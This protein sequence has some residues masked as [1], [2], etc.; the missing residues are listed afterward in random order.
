MRQRIPDWLNEYVDAL[1]GERSASS[2]ARK[3]ETE[4]QARLMKISRR[5]KRHAA[6]GDPDPDP[7]FV[8]NLESQMRGV[9]ADSSP[10]VRRVPFLRLAW[11]RPLAGVAA[12][13][14]VFFLAFLLLRG[15]LFTVSP[16]AAPV[17]V[18]REQ[19]QAPAQAPPVA[20]IPAPAA[21]GPSASSADKSAAGQTSPISPPA[22]V[23][24]PSAVTLAEVV[25]RA[26]TI[27]IV[28]VLATPSLP[29]LPPGVP[30]PGGQTVAV[31]AERY[32]KGALPD[33][34][35]IL[36]IGSVN[37]ETF[38]YGRR[39]LVMIGSREGDAF[40]FKR[41]LPDP[42]AAYFLTPDGLASPLIQSNPPAPGDLT[43]AQL[44]GQIEAIV[45][46]G[47]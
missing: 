39:L 4:E 15:P 47:Q 9:L 14:A 7:E 18:M 17:A 24:G 31:S 38:L 28:T 41:V 5:L 20:T 19:A 23:P 35:W 37:A 6:R 8:A 1:L 32:L 34:Q 3:A 16:A 27:A 12:A 25:S 40:P 22:A 45:K 33:K 26:Q 30:P 2:S 44:V 21:G 43:E 13:A 10:R 29:G 42:Q 46:G 36:Q 11:V